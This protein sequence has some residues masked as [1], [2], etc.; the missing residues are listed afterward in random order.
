VV[1]SVVAID[2]LL[3]PTAYEVTLRTTAR[4]RTPFSRMVVRGAAA[5]GSAGA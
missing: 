4:R 5:I 2:Q 1:V 3:L